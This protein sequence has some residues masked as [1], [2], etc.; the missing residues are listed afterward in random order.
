[1]GM[2]IYPFIFLFALSSQR[3]E[4]KNKTRLPLRLAQR[5]SSKALIRLKECTINDLPLM[6]SLNSEKCLIR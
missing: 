6:E 1:M 2:S 3:F 4:Q 5:S